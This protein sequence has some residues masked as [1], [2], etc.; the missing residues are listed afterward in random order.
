MAYQFQ[1]VPHNFHKYVYNYSILQQQKEGSNMG[2]L[3]Q[4][5]V[6][7]SLLDK[8]SHSF[9][10]LNH[11]GKYTTDIQSLLRGIF[12]R[13]LIHQISFYSFPIFLAI[14]RQKGALVLAW[15]HYIPQMIRCYHYFFISQVLE[16]RLFLSSFQVILCQQLLHPN[17]AFLPHE[18]SAVFGSPK[19]RCRYLHHHSP[20][21]H[22]HLRSLQLFAFL[23][24]DFY[25]FL[26][27]FPSEFNFL[28]LNLFPLYIYRYYD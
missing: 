7:R 2:T 12:P 26:L 14:R 1:N 11:P 25:Y 5:E 13:M 17:G 6:S 4:G 15:V 16:G 8:N 9:L 21:H 23:I 22:I 10:R 28:N 20:H 3:L 18:V 24:F 19:F 27:Q